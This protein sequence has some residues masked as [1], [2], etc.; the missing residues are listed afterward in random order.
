[1][2][3]GQV[4]VLDYLVKIFYV[5]EVYERFQYKSLKLRITWWNLLGECKPECHNTL[6]LGGTCR[7]YNDDSTILSSRDVT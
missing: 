3:V 5:L 1:M 4:F 6:E 7:L 2:L